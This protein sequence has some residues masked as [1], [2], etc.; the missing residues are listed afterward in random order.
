VFEQLD[1]RISPED[2]LRLG[3]ELRP[4]LPLCTLFWLAEMGTLEIHVW[5]SRVRAEDAASARS[6][7]SGSAANLVDSQVNFPDYMLFDLDPYIYSGKERS[8]GDPEP[9]EEGFEQGRQVAFW[10]KEVLDGMSLRSFVKTTG[11]TGL[12]VVVPITSTLRYDVVRSLA[13]AICQH[14]LRQHPEAITTEWDTRKRRGKVF[15]DFNMNV[16]GKSTIAPYC[17]RGIAGAPVSRPLTW[18]ELSTAKPMQFRIGTL[19]T[20]RKLSDPWSGVLD[21]KQDLEGK[22]R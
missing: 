17:P 7:S 10:L 4:G 2:R 8:G 22:V 12:H 15:M 11:K 21:H 14:L 6:P 9:S 16:R 5:H 19:A 1:R 18:R 13:G 20:G 3:N